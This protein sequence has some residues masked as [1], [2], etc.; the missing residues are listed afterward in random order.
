M[1]GA[2]VIVLATTSIVLALEN[3]D[4]KSSSQV[5]VYRN[6]DNKSSV[7]TTIA[8]KS[9]N[10]A[11][12]MDRTLSACNG[13]GYLWEG[14]M[15]CECMDCY[16]GDFC[17]QYVGDSGCVINVIGGTPLIF[18]EYWVTQPQTEIRIQ[19]SRQVR[20]LC[21]LMTHNKILFSL[22]FLFRLSIAYKT[23]SAG[24]GHGEGQA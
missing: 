15:S 9:G 13:H 3:Q 2:A 11:P 24:E 23:V 8:S 1:L 17:D 18:V 16:T 5:K 22:F 19:M 12:A 14:S 4:L 6:P 21:T 20:Y 10:L 7:S